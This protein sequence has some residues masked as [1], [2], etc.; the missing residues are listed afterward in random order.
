MKRVAVV[1]VLGL[2]V[3]AVAKELRHHLHL[4][5]LGRQQQRGSAG[6]NREETETIG[7]QICCTVRSK[8]R[9]GSTYLVPLLQTDGPVGQAR[10]QLVDVSGGDECRHRRLRQQ[11]QSTGRIVLQHKKGAQLKLGRTSNCTKVMPW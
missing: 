1:I 11:G 4:A 8:Q 6:L 2:V 10:A 3:C 9:E 5:Q 7:I